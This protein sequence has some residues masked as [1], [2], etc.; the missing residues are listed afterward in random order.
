MRIGSNSQ[1]KFANIL[2]GS[3]F[4]MHVFVCNHYCQPIVFNCMV[5]CFEKVSRTCK[6]FV[7]FY[8]GIR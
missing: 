5:L 8:F 3:Q 1:H 2:L 4:D 6:V 7:L